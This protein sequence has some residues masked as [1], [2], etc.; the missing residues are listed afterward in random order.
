MVNRIVNE[1]LI[2]IELVNK[3]KENEKV[4]KEYCS[5]NSFLLEYLGEFLNDIK[6]L[7]KSQALKQ[8]EEFEQVYH[9]FSFQNNDKGQAGIEPAKSPK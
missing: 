8:I 1:L 3:L 4:L 6:Y 2:H 9:Y 7:K 5:E